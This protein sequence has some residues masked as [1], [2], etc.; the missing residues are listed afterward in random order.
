MTK[1]K[2]IVLILG[3]ITVLTFANTE[4]AWAQTS[5]IPFVGCKSD[6]QVGP[7]DAPPK[8]SNKPRVL[9]QH[10]S[11]LAWYESEELGVL[12]PRGWHCFGLSGSDASMLFVTPEDHSQR[13]FDAKLNSSAIELSFH[14]G[15]TSGRFTAAKIAARLFPKHRA[16]VNSVIS[17]GIMAKSDFPIGPFPQDKIRNI[18]PDFV[19][20]ET[21]ANTNGIGTMSRLVK[22]NAPIQGWAMIDEGNNVTM[23]TVRLAP[24]MQ[25]LAPIIL[26]GDV[27]TGLPVVKAFYGA[28]S[29][30]QGT[31]AS[32]R[33][34][35][36]KR[37]MPQ[38]AAAS[39][40]QFYGTL[41]VPLRLGSIE[42][43]GPASYL[44]HYTYTA[45]K[46]MCD[47]SALVKTIVQDKQSYISS[48]KSLNGC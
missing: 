24:A 7:Q 26:N 22:S 28:L 19:T 9:A 3:A 43:A 15:E 17:E 46:T 25:D 6:G 35:P 2:I 45:S 39:M 32:E 48:I 42:A 38:F 29:K 14:S 20:F 21:P 36:E 31:E 16:F 13:L 37:S 8:A 40:S 10:A 30:G 33:I 1:R 41:K 11:K 47:G 44:V 5:D 4:P 34:A 12:A 27:D 18:G 23:L